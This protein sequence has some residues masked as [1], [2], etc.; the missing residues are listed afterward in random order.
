IAFGMS[1]SGTEK[2]GDPFANPTAL[3]FDVFLKLGGVV[4]LIYLCYLLVRRWQGGSTWKPAARRM[5]VIETVHLTPRRALHLVQ[6]GDQTLLIGATDQSVSL[7][8]TVTN[9]EAVQPV[10]ASESPAPVVKAEPES[11][12]NLLALATQPAEIAGRQ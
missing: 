1:L 10:A 3:A 7:I 9:G 6:V 4:L 11:F 12:A 8:S 5:N 2:V